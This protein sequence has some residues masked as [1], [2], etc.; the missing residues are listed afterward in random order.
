MHVRNDVPAVSNVLVWK[1]WRGGG[2]E[3]TEEEAVTLE[4]PIILGVPAV[5]LHCGS[6]GNRWTWW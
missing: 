2:G 6:A 1:R 5:V 4:A 3:I